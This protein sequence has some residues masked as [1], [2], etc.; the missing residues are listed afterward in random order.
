[1]IYIRVISLSFCLFRICP[2]KLK[3]LVL[4][5]SNS[6][7]IMKKIFLS[8]VIIALLFSACK[9]DD[10]VLK[11]EVPMPA[12]YISENYTSNAETQIALRSRMAAVASKAK[13]V[14]TAG[15]S[16]TRQELL[17]L[18]SAGSPAVQ[19]VITSYF[20]TVLS[21]SSGYFQILEDASAGSTY[22]PG[23]PQGQ[24]G[25]L[26][27][28]V[29]DEFGIEPDEIIDKGMYAAV[30]YNLATNYMSTS[31]QP[32]DVDKLVALFGANPSFPNSGSSNVAQPDVMMANYAARRDKND[33]NGIY[34]Q[35]KKSAIA[36]RQYI[37]A[38]E[39]YTA[40]R[41][42]ALKDVKK[43]WELASAA[44]VINYLH[45]AIGK[46]TLSNPT[47]AD[48]ASGLHAYSEGVGFIWGWKT[49]SQSHKIITD[50]QIDEILGLMNAPAGANPTT[51]TFITDPVNQVPKLSTAI[52]RLKSIYGFT[53]QEI[54]DFRKNW[55]VEQG[56]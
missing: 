3:D 32:S 48:Y 18:Y 21:G 29:F 36:L 10:V 30:L 7:F 43:Y 23:E 9:K 12:D 4:P 13:T 53:S 44:T 20:N 26:E 39:N 50:T 55:V 42:A 27:G 49:I 17:D 34:T 28:R 46:F 5:S 38:G 47:N 31:I 52:D 54:E 33:G 1:M 15:V 19:S 56:R 25:F 41:D 40:E 6:T 51:Y 11:P 2:N 35:F 14:R 8:T 16:V 24:G 37:A 22:V 45:S